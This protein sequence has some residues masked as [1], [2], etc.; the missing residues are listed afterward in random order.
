MDDQDDDM[1]VIAE[2]ERDVLLVLLDIDSSTNISD[3]VIWSDEEGDNGSISKHGGVVTM[4]STNFD[5]GDIGS[6]EELFDNEDDVEVE[7]R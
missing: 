2:A 1:I 6:E 3:E 4:P 7:G 5:R